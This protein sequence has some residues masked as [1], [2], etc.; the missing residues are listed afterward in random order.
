[1][2]LVLAA[3]FPQHQLDSRSGANPHQRLWRQ[4]PSHFGR[5]DPRHFGRQ[6]PLCGMVLFAAYARKLSTPANVASRCQS[7]LVIE[8]VKE[9]RFQHFVCNVACPFN[10]ESQTGLKGV[11][12]LPHAYGPPCWRDF[13]FESEGQRPLVAFEMDDN[14]MGGAAPLTQIKNRSEWVAFSIVPL[15]GLTQIK[16]HFF[17]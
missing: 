8:H 13:L 5:Q 16:H 2:L 12:S 3:G 10:K 17:I 7:R 1:M 4:D 11:E 9:K 15:S 14:I 6:D